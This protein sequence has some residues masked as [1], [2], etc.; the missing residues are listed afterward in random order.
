MTFRERDIAEGFEEH[1]LDALFLDVSNPRD[2]LS[3]IHAALAGGSFF[4]SILPPT[5]QV[6]NLV[7]DLQ[8]SDFGLIE[9]EELPLGRYKTV[10]V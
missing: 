2:Y 1:K 5:N 9:M 10:S 3:Q 8:S 4:G 7:T 6:I